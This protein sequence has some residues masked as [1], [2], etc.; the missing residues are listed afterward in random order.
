MRTP[1]ALAAALTATAALTL[2]A[3]G[4]GDASRATAGDEPVV[5][6]DAT[7][8]N[9]AAAVVLDTPF[10]KPDLVL[11]DTRGRR[12]DLRENTKDKLTLVYFGYTHCPDACPL[13][14]SNLALAYKDLSQ[15]DRDRLRVVFVTTD[16]ERD[17][18]AELGKWL[19]SAGHADFVGLS[20]DYQAVEDAARTV[21]V[22]MEP[23]TKNKEGKVTATHGKTVLAFFA[24]DD[25][26]HVLYHGDEATA[27]DYAED[28]PKLLK[29]QTP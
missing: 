20:G 24:K 18:P 1:I 11:T 4:S 16:P 9:R 8:R 2:T 13:T 19:P 22:G 5:I 17:T 10:A 29:G 6:T 25:K 7:A 28:L 14:M 21:G 26:A 27:E 12:F 3:C 23:A 15:S